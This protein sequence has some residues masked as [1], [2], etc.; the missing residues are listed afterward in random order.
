MFIFNENQQYILNSVKDMISKGLLKSDVADSEEGKVKDIIDKLF[1]AGI[2]NPNLPKEYGGMDLDTV[3]QIII[4][5]LVAKE[6]PTIAHIMGAHAYGFSQVIADFGNEAQ[7]EKYLR[8]AAKDKKIGTFAY[9]E[10]VGCNLNALQLK[11]VKKENTYVLN[12]TKAMITMASEADYLL[13]FAKTNNFGNEFQ[14]FSMFVVDTKKCPGISFG[15]KE[16]LMG[17]DGLTI[18]EVV[19]DDCIVDQ[20]CMIGISGDGVKI[21][22]KQLEKSRIANGASAIGMAERAY[23]EALQYSNNRIMNN[24]PLMQNP[25][26][27]S[28]LSKMKIDLETIKLLV[29]QAAMCCDLGKENQ[30][31]N[32]SVAKF[33]ATEFAKKIIDEAVQIHG[34]V[35]YMKEYFVERLYRDIRIYTLLGGTSELILSTTGRELLKDI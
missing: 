35:G 10:P 7:K 28:K 27:T 30:I 29:F 25:V 8:D 5:Y 24:I 34:G 3:S 9:T 19:F 14:Q 16:S 32:S 20:D 23:I 21:L 11:A 12:G 6:Q 18:N 22:L 13:T 17:L 15:K 33:Q 31:F 1:N 4:L 2:M 26:I